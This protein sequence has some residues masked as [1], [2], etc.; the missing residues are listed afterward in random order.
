[1]PRQSVVV[2]AAAALAVAGTVVGLATTRGSRA[3]S[4]TAAPP[5]AA[6]ATPRA[7]EPSR[8]VPGLNRPSPTA[9]P[10]PSR[11]PAPSPPAAHA[12]TTAATPR[13]RTAPRAARSYPATLGR[14]PTSVAQAITVTASG[15]GATT[16]RLEAWTR[17]GGG[18]SRAFGPWTA[19]L[20]YT[21]LAHPGAKRE[22]D[23]HTPSGVYGFSYL[24]GI[25][26][27][28]GVHD[29]YRQVTGS[30]D[31]WDDDPSSPRY[32]EWVDTHSADAG[33]SPEP[34]DN[35]PS[36]LYGAVIGYNTARTP[37]LGSAIFLHVTK[38]G[39]T[40]GCVAI[41][42]GDLVPLLRWMRPGTE[43]SIG[44]G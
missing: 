12:A 29:T 38:G 36:Y 42:E 17:T 15:Y 18:W 24:F 23:G 32:N 11:R 4:V 14:V 16:A 22:G 41:P 26:P 28:P 30:Y 9:T 44:V 35:P 27:D 8:P 7:P 40:A 3:A 2:G 19:N 25:E 33:R 1:M 39:S 6:A 37:G 43:I 13:A 21:G 10:P 31:V 20:G 34:M 5:S